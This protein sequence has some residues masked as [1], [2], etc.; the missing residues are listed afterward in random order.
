[1]ARC[2]WEACSPYYNGTWGELQLYSLEL[3]YSLR[4]KLEQQ[5][6]KTI[7]DLCKK[8]PEDLLE[9]QDLTS[10]DVMKIRTTLTKWMEERNIVG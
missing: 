7:G 1:M 8:T 3:S 2:G 6:I 10:D 4:W 5:N 9:I